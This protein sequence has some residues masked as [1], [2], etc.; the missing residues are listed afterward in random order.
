MFS[1][2]VPMRRLTALVLEGDARSVL[3]DWGELGAVE[4]T[5]TPCGPDTVPLPPRERTKER[6]RGER[7]RA[8][9]ADL[10]RSLGA[11]AD[12]QEAEI[13]PAGPAGEPVEMTLD[14]IEEVMDAMEARAAPWLRRRQALRE[15]WAQLDTTSRQLAAYRDLDLP[16]DGAD[17]YAFLHF[18]TGHLPME[19]WQQ[20]QVPAGEPVALL[21]LPVEQG[22][23]P[24]IALTTQRG[25]RALEAVL[26]EAGFEAETLP[27]A[28]GST[29]GAWSGQCQR[30]LESVRQELSEVHVEMGRLLVECAAPLRRVEQVVETELR[31]IEAES[32]FPRTETAALLGGWVPADRVAVVEDRLLRL[33][34]GCCVLE[35][36]PADAG[37]G[38]S[39]PVLLCHP[40]WLR[41]FERLVTV[42]GLPEYGE[43]EPTFWVA[44]SFLVMFGMMFGD[45]GH[46]AVLALAGGWFW[47]RGRNQGS[48]VL[49]REP[50]NPVGR[51]CPGA[52]PRA[53]RPYLVPRFRG[54]I[55]RTSSRSEP[56]NPCK[57]SNVQR[58]TSNAATIGNPLSVE[59]LPRFRGRLWSD[60]GV[61]LVA[62]GG[63][64]M[65]FGWIY[66]SCFGLEWF[67][68]H[69]LWRDPLEG[70]PLGLIR[71][72]LVMGV[73]MISLGLVLNI[74]NRLRRGDVWGG[75]LD[76]FGLVGVVFYWG[77]LVWMLR[78]AGLEVWR[79]GLLLGVG[80]ALLGMAL[81][82]PLARGV[83]RPQGTEGAG[84]EGWAGAL[85]ESVV[86]AFEAVLSYLAN[87]ISFVRLAAYAMSHAA[88]LAA[89]FAVAAQL[90]H[91]PEI[92]GMLAVGM[93]VLG[94]VGALALEGL[95]A[96]VQ[97]LRLEYYEFFGKFF[98]GS[99][100]PFAP[101]RLAAGA[102]ARAG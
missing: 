7:L 44:L 49:R 25:W 48:P 31:L 10:R 66:G 67:K 100:R 32:N 65:V 17:G 51:R 52:G 3:R 68:H 20:V 60:L 8:R 75:C 39:V 80:L 54:R 27:V 40:R 102:R 14:A 5:R 97:A 62:G 90:R 98:S 61:V 86:G 74:I 77:A 30:E 28:A 95:I 1:S 42:Y 94:N 46:G 84:G 6:E 34:S 96:T 78:P 72:A 93:I 33:T 23:Q 41:P 43:V 19:R 13:L 22:R 59:C 12:G 83:K 92:G 85:I 15:R 87:T 58:S 79:G 81:R 88:L 55:P 26:R 99:G 76:P 18:A 63:A 56:L 4:L 57:T 64:S 21:P 37:P 82:E 69:A 29:S 16:L 50:L 73:M 47:W 35:V 2:V 45:V 53:A 11:D 38:E 71:W 36:C 70:D 89:V 101:F 91:V 24:L 9:I